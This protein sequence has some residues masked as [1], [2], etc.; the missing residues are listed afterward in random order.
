MEP[1]LLFGF[2]IACLLLLLSTGLPIAFSLGMVGVIGFLVFLTPN[3]LMQVARVVYTHGMSP[4][5]I[6]VPL[7]VLM[8]EIISSSGYGKDIYSA[9]HKWL[10]WLPGSLASCTVAAAAVFAAV[11][12]SSVAT[13]ATVGLV[14]IPQMLKK[15]YSKR[16]ACGATAA[17]GGLGILIPPSLGFIIYGMVT[18]TSIAKLFMAGF[19]PGI[20]MAV[21]LISAITIACAARPAL[22]PRGDER[23]E[24]RERFRSLGSVLPIGGLIVVVLGSIYLG[25]ATVEEA[26]AVGAVGSLVIAA[27]YRRLTWTVL[28]S[29]LLTTARVTGMVFFI[30]FGGMLFA[31]LVTSLQI[32]QAMSKFIGSLSVNRWVILAAINVMYLILGCL[33]EGIAMTVIT[34]PFIFPMITA[35]GF[36]PIWFGVIM[37]LNIEIGLLT[38]PVGMNLFVVRGIAPPNVAWSDII[39]GSLPF[40][41]VDVVGMI[42]LMI[43][44]EIALWLP[45]QMK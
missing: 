9:L 13:A 5:L 32:P 24:W 26:A 12:G 45:S 11:C 16:L 1:F 38:P 7:F 19:V 30:V 4:T 37:I 23:I 25:V 31:Y 33:F 2:F 22:A 14:G 15:G 3:D 27:A 17:G 28:Q 42:I 21:L 35:L 29:A 6:V 43:F 10:N 20:M 18:E 8:A 44:P 34:M 36:D 40:V 39:Y 41:L